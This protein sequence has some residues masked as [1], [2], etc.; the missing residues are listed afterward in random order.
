[1]P[2]I[3]VIPTGELEGSPAIRLVAPAQTEANYLLR[4]FTTKWRAG[5]RV[6]WVDDADWGSSRFD[7]CV[8]YLLS[9]PRMEELIVW[10]DRGVYEEAWCTTPIWNCVNA[11]PLFATPKTIQELLNELVQAPFIPQPA[12]L[13]VHDPHRNNLLPS[14]LDEVATRLDPINGGWI[15][16]DRDAPKDYIETALG[17]CAAASSR[18]GVRF[19]RT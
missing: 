1:V 9:D 4:Q 16:A 12:E 15:Y 5:T 7:D 14:L 8:S 6:L 18:W 10:A 17:A 19:R 13:I 2:E 3:D 11:S